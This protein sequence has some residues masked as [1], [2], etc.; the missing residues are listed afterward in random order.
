MRKTKL[1]LGVASFAVLSILNFTQSDRNFLQSTLASSGKCSSCNSSC[2]CGCISSSSSLMD[3]DD[4]NFA[5][6][7]KLSSVECPI[8]KI[9]GSMPIVVSGVKIEPGAS[10]VVNGTKLDCTFYL[11]AKCDQRKVTLCQEIKSKN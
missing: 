11:L 1:F 2:T 8:T 7:S 5:Y 9:N 10:Y 6:A 3:T 4:P